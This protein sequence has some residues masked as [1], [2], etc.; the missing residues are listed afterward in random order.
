M[1]KL[2]GTQGREAISCLFWHTSRRDE[3][4]RGCQVRSSAAVWD[5]ERGAGHG[6][7]L[8]ELAANQEQRPVKTGEVKNTKAE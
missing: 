3:R 2:A 1:C 8:C 4:G 6:K 7:G 5:R